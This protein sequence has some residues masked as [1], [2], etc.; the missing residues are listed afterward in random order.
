MARRL[1]RA[2]KPLFAVTHSPN[3]GANYCGIICACN[4][5]YWM[6]ASQ[7]KEIDHVV[8]NRSKGNQ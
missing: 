6:D 4:N 8:D 7:R 1:R 2:I 5:V 3:V